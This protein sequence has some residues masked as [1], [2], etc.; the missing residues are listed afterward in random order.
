[1]YYHPSSLPSYPS[2]DHSTWS[3][4][5]LQILV[6]PTFS[7]LCSCSEEMPTELHR[8]KSS[9]SAI[10]SGS[11]KSLNSSS[12]FSRSFSSRRISGMLRSTS[13]SSENMEVLP[14]RRA[15]NCAARLPEITTL[16]NYDIYAAQVPGITA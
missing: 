3:S 10:L 9:K 16:E 8:P 1:M 13:V 2:H 4:Y 6:H 7:D 14:R 5:P 15:D 12:N 11:P